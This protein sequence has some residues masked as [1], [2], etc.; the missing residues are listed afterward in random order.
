MKIDVSGPRPRNADINYLL[1][2]FRGFIKLEKEISQPPGIVSAVC[3]PM[4]KG[5]GFN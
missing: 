5:T 4:S 3:K 1:T 2:L